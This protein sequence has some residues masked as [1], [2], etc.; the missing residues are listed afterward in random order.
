MLHG[1][2]GGSEFF[3]DVIAKFQTLVSPM[4]PAL[5]GHAG[6]RESEELRSFEA[7]ADRLA[8][9]ITRHHASIPVHLVGYSLGSRLALSL[10]IRAPSLFRSAT[11]ISARRGLDTTAER[12]QRSQT[13]LQWAQRLRTVPLADFLNAWE[14]RPIFSTMRQMAPDKLRRL[15]EQRLSHDSEGLAQALLGLSLSRMPSYASDLT[16]IHVPVT[17]VVGSLDKKFVELGM[18]LTSRLPNSKSIVVNGSGHNLPIERPD[19]V[20]AAIIEGMNHD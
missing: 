10:L 14:N 16:R 6:F 18:E 15:R 1:F 20:A 2:L 19:V 12:E 8:C 7:E 17:L 13:D 9:L 3:S 5:Y 4:V 11:L